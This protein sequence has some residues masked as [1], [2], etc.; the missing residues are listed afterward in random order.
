MSGIWPWVGLAALGTF[1]G[2]NP[3]M[4]WLFA[5]ALG[6]HR[7]SR[8]TVLLSLLPIAAGHAAAVLIV[9]VAVTAFGEVVDPG[10]VRRASGIL[11]IGWAVFHTLYG[12]RHRVRFGMRVGMAGLAAWSFLMALAHGAGLMLIPLLGPAGGGAQIGLA[13]GL[14]A[15]AVHSIAMLA[16]TALVALLVYEWL[17]VAVLRWG[18][19]NLDIVWTAA[20][21]AAGLLL[22][23]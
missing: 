7:N 18:W 15:V 5:V 16:T 4:G 2:L 12:H 6:L 1:H 10:I 8:R 3:A 19:I 23:L 13:T 9:V 11:L 21:V 17:G 20:L 22:L 14:E